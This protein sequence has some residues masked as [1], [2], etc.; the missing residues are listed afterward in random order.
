MLTNPAATNGILF[1]DPQSSNY[2]KRFYRVIQQ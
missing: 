1:M 2:P